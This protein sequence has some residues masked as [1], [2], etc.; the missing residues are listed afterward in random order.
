MIVKKDTAA[1]KCEAVRIDGV[2]VFAFLQQNPNFQS[3]SVGS[4]KDFTENFFLQKRQ[5]DRLASFRFS[6]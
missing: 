6:T 5:P 4:R 1:K 2:C 3:S